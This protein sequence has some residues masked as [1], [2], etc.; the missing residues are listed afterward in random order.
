MLPIPPIPLEKEPDRDVLIWGTGGAAGT[1][2]AL[3]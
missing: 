1:V 3:W 2:L